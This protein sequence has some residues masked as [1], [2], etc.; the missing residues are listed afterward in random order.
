MHIPNNL[1]DQCVDFVVMLRRCRAEFSGRPIQHCGHEKHILE[2][3]HY[4]LT[5]QMNAKYRADK[6]AKLAS[7]AAIPAADAHH[8]H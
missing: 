5:M 6:F 1:R 3:C 8:H 7:S 2:H 4:E